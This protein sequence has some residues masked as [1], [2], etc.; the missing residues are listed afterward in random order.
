MMHYLAEAVMNIRDN[1][2]PKSNSRHNGKVNPNFHSR[3]ISR[4]FFF[5]FLL[6]P[7]LTTMRIMYLHFALEG[8]RVRDRTFFFA[9]RSCIN[10][11]AGSFL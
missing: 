8:E 2:E 4:F 11:G 3:V 1:L 6:L 10:G 9:C 5:S 7:P